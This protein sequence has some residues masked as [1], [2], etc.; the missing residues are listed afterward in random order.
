MSQENVE[1]VRALYELTARGDFSAMDAFPDDFEFVTS[2]ELPDAGTYKAEAARHFIR[3]WIE[4]FQQLTIDATEIIG[5]GEKV[6]IAIVQRGRPRGTDTVV[7][8]RWWQVVTFRGAEIARIETFAERAQ[9]L[10]AVGLE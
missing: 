6:V 7:E 1:A 9:A 4:S 2:P 5:A 8:G 10:K 3:G